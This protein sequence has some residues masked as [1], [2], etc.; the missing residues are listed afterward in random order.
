MLEEQVGSTAVFPE[1]AS[2]DARVSF[3]P[4]VLD[5]KERTL[6]RHDAEIDLPERSL[7]LLEVL[8][9]FAGKTVSKDRLVEDVWRGSYVSDTSL[10]EAMSRLRRSL[11]DEARE[12]RYI[13]TVHR[14]GY[15][16]IAPIRGVGHHSGSGSP[17]KRVWMPVW[18]V[19]SIAWL[20]VLWIGSV[21]VDDR[22]GP[23]SSSPSFLADS[24]VM[25]FDPLQKLTKSLLG[26]AT[27]DTTPLRPRYR[28]AEVT[29]HSAQPW[30]Y[31]IPALPLSDLS[32]DRTGHRLA[33]SIA[34]GR[35]SDAWVLEPREGRFKRITT[36]GYFSDPVWTPNGQAV[37]LAYRRNGDFDLVLKEVDGDG[38]AQVLLEAPLDQFPESWS[39][40]GRSLIYSERHP[41]TGYDLWL[42][43]QRNDDSWVPIPLVRTAHNEAFGAISPDGRYVAYSSRGGQR[44]DVFVVDLKS[45]RSTFEVSREGGAYP[46]WS[47]TG[48]RL[49]Y[50]K[51]NELW[52]VATDQIGDDMTRAPRT[53]TTVPGL[54]LA[55][56][57]SAGDRI[58]VAMLD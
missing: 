11:G 31:S 48:D 42:L 41:E 37:A 56:S 53:S 17:T 54:Y 22:H 50:V 12:P 58:V 8:V 55:G 30:K 57:A 5:R 6:Q 24:P 15:R 28:L 33:F 46:F 23:R 2:G 13:R 4:F 32:V 36:G 1:Q 35:Q 18:M 47:S 27:P 29:I 40:D 10:T 38:A 9:H 7:R 25:V 39:Q 14:R 49:H 26:V 51:G 52:T 3:G 16:F 44:P 19:A 21:L 34:D 20:G 43:H 45:N